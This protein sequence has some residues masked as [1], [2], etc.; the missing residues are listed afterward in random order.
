MEALEL[1]ESDRR[2]ARAGFDDVADPQFR[3]ESN[4]Y[5]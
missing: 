3:Q 1:G 4:F 2:E 5:P